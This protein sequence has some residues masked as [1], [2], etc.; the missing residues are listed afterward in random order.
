MF[1]VALF[2]KE[3]IKKWCKALEDKTYCTYSI[4][5]TEKST[6][7]RV[8][9]KQRLHCHHNTRC[10]RTY[11]SIN[12]NKTR[13]TNCP[14][15]L[16]ITLKTVRKGYRGNAVDPAMP[17]IIS[18]VITHNHNILA[19]DALRFRRVNPSTKCKLL[20][21]FKAGHSPATSI[22]IL[23]MDIQLNNNANYEEL[24]GMYTYTLNDIKYLNIV[25]V[26]SGSKHMP[27]LQLLLLS[28]YGRI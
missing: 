20:E 17:C 15:K 4:R 6:A 16:N 3:D 1:K 7:Q 25:I 28:I 19:A 9:F 11:S 12:R 22:E 8:Q 2:N 26:F 18:Y 27:R 10:D 24:L 14:S 21:L 5:S 13:N 23:K